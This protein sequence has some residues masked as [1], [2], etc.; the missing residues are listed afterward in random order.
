MNAEKTAQ[1]IADETGRPCEAGPS[2][3]PI[4]CRYIAGHRRIGAVDAV[5]ARR[6]IAAEL[7]AELA[8]ME[9]VESEE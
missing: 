9:R 8:E 7:A 1:K 5:D 4:M 3:G 6:L 2:G